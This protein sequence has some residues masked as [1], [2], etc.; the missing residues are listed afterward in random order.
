M[1]SK[2]NLPRLIIVGYNYYHLVKY[3]KKFII[4][5]E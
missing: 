2:S 5:N 3:S 4:R 1:T